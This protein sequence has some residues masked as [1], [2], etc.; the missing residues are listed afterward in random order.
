MGNQPGKSTASN[1]GKAIKQENASDGMA[2]R[3]AEHFDKITHVGATDHGKRNIDLQTFK[4]L[5]SLDESFGEKMFNCWLRSVET[6]PSNIAMSR[7]QFFNFATRIIDLTRYPDQMEFYFEVFS[8]GK[9]SLSTADFSAL[10]KLCISLELV[11]FNTEELNVNQDPILKSMETSLFNKEE[12]MTKGDLNYWMNRHCPKLMYG[13]HPYV[14]S[15]L[16]DSAKEEDH[17]TPTGDTFQQVKDNQLMLSFSLLWALTT[18]MPTSYTKHVVSQASD[19]S[20]LQSHS[21][22]DILGPGGWQLLYNSNTQGLSLNRFENHVMSY[23]AP[24]LTLIEFE[25]HSYCVGSDSEWVEK[26]ERWGGPDCFLL[27]V[28]PE[29]RIIQAGAGLLYL[30]IQDRKL[31]KGLYFGKDTRSTILQI[32]SDFT[33]VKHYGIEIALERIEVWGCGSHSTYETQLAQRKWEHRDAERHKNIKLKI[34]DWKDNPDR[35]L[36]EMGGIQTEHTER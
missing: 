27:Q 4:C 16:Y 6:L 8:D 11:R 2:Q 24:T 12:T 5:F 31:P 32:D 1:T 13:I 7:E 36:L 15:V 34:E 3:L 25:G 17:T 22:V 18:Y 33:K 19:A 23:T 21:L 9:D 10:V 28:F 30:N 29:Y 14:L 20:I 35:Q 26:A